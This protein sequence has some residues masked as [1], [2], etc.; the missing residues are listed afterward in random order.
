MKKRI[1]VAALAASLCIS[2]IAQK[3]YWEVGG[4]AAPGVG[5]FYG[6][7]AIRSDTRPSLTFAAGLSALYHFTPLLSLH[8]DLLYERKGAVSQIIYTTD[9]GDN[10]IGKK[11]ALWIDYITLPLMARVTV[12]HKVK[13]TAEVGPYIGARIAQSTTMRDVYDHYAS[14]TRPWDAG[15]CVAAGLAVPVEE[16]FTL[17]IEARDNVGLVNVANGSIG[18]NGVVLPMSTGT[19]R[20]HTTMLHIMLTYRLPAHG[21]RA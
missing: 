12:G 6:N 1:F 15:I 14:I 9:Q 3:S 17:S 19:V 5:L 8:G 4:T 21:R 20:H 13:L 11:S 18:S 7:S 16:R 2:L 10:F